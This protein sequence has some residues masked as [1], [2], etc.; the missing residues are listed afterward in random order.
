MNEWGNA[1]CGWRTKYEIYV[2]IQ[3]NWFIYH[4]MRAFAIYIWIVIA[5]NGVWLILR[6]LL[7]R[8]LQMLDVWLMCIMHVQSSV[9][10]VTNSYVI[11]QYFWIKDVLPDL[12][13]KLSHSHSQWHTERSKG[14]ASTRWAF[15]ELGLV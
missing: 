5:G 9:M 10:N 2:T 1:E 7:F 6:T 13:F 12:K 3:L 14:E 4:L 8:F 11:K 15:F